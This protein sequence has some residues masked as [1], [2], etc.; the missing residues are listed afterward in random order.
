MS[1]HTNCG[2]GV[3]LTIMCHV[4]MQA[5]PSQ[6]T[7]VSPA[8][9]LRH[10][11]ASRPSTIKQEGQGHDDEPWNQDL[12]QTLL[13]TIYKASSSTPALCFC[14]RNIQAKVDRL[15]E[16]FLNTLKVP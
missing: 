11:S 9:L 4:P 2:Y 12:L 1:Y 5:L 16:D 7:L 6:A 3:N 14:S 15:D 13:A 10:V 8:A